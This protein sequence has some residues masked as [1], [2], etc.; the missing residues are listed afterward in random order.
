MLFIT[1]SA[2]AVRQRQRPAAGPSSVAPRLLFVRGAEA[3]HR[4][5]MEGT[6][7]LAVIGERPPLVVEVPVLV[8]A[9]HQHR[10]EP[11]PASAAN[12][13]RDVADAKPDP[14]VVSPV[15]SG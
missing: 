15:R 1:S 13:R 10:G 9:T 5:R 6:L 3:R 4:L 14:P 2:R 8:A 12:V 11:R 7:V